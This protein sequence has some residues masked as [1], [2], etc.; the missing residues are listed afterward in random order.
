M[1]AADRALAGPVIFQ[2]AHCACGVGVSDLATAV[3]GDRL[4]AA[5]GTEGP[6]DVLILQYRTVMVR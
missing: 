3:E 5:A 1:S 2:T 6:V 4:V